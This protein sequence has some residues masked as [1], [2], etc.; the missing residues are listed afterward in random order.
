[1]TNAEPNFEY[2]VFLSH[3]AKDKAVVR[4]VAERLRK[5]GLKVWFDEWVLKPGD[6]IP[7]KIEEG[8]EHSRVL[9]LCM[10]AN[11]FGSDWAQLEAGTFR[12]RD[13][14]NKERRFI[15][16][17]LDDAPIKGSLAQFLYINWLPADREQEYAKL[18]EACSRTALLPARS[19]IV[20]YEETTR[21][22]E[23]FKGAPPVAFAVT[24]LSSRAGEEFRSVMECAG[25]LNQAFAEAGVKSQLH[26]WEQLGHVPDGTNIF[27]V[28]NTANDDMVRRIIDAARVKDLDPQVASRPV[29]K[30]YDIDLM[31]GRNP[32]RA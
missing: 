2:D 22:I 8:L 9:V 15:P 26:L 5:D 25:W 1:M 30:G 27:W 13:P 10:S 11:A 20:T 29:T 28:K 14:L 32:Y 23:V 4:A 6:S 17:R 12:F 18:L 24:S 19:A 3:S 31:I 21:I 7:A 16:L